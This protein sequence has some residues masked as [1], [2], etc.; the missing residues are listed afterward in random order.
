MRGRNNSRDAVVRQTPKGA[1][2]ECRQASSRRVAKFGMG[3]GGG[4][5]ERGI[6]RMREGDQKRTSLRCLFGGW[7]AGGGG[8]GGRCERASAERASAQRRKAE[9]R[10]QGEEGAIGWVG[11]AHSW[12]GAQQNTLLG[13]GGWKCC[14][15]ATSR[16]AKVVQVSDAE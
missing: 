6:V 12:T 2:A 14:A 9:K 5:D 3:G 11:G 16:G 4:R 13:G 7:R 1:T 8:G 10:R 15:V